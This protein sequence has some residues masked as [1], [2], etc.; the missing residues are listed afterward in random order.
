M[1]NIISLTFEWFQNN[2]LEA[3]ASIIGLGNIYFG[4]KEK[5][6]FWAIAIINSLLFFFLYFQNKLYA[7]MSLQVYYMGLGIYGLYY[8]IK[9]SGKTSKQK[10]VVNKAGLKNGIFIFISFIIVFAVI[11]FILKKFTDSQLPFMDSLTTS[12]A[13]IAAY[14]MV[15]KHI[16][17]WYVWFASDLITISLLF[18]KQLYGALILQIFYFVF[19]IVGFKE[20][21]KSMLKNK[22]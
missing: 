6:V 19:A 4:I 12:S 2:T 13:I 18:Y 11:Y 9:G 5:P 3:I 16:E 10:V 1:N 14:M 7:Y 21:R 15:K 22:D 20:W 17:N 8:W